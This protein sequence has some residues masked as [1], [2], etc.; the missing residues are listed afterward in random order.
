M[1]NFY[2]KPNFSGWDKAF[3]IIG[4]APQDTKNE[5]MTERKTKLISP[6]QFKV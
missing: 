5:D 4:F 6:E 3:E 2:G 1:N